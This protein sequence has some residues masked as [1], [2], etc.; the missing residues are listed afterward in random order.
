MRKILVPLAIT[1]IAV[2]TGCQEEIVNEV[3]PEIKLKTTSVS[4]PDTG[5]EGVIVFK[6]NN[7]SADGKLV[8]TSADEWISGLQ[9]A[10]DTTVVFT[11]AAND[12][13]EP[14]NGKVTLTY[15]WGT[16]MSITSEVPVTLLAAAEEPEPEVDY[17]YEFEMP[18]L[19]GNFYTDMGN[20]GEYNYYTWLMDVPFDENGNP[21]AGGT[22]YLLDIFAAET[23]SDMNN[24]LPPAGTYVLG[25][26]MGTADMTFGYDYSIVEAYDENMTATMRRHFDGG[27]VEISYEGS[28]IVIDA[29]LADEAEETHHVTYKGQPNFTPDDGGGEDPDNPSDDYMLKEDLDIN[30]TWAS[31]EYGYDDGYVMQVSMQFTD[32]EVIGTSATPP[33]NLLIVDTYMPPKYDG[34]LAT[35]Y[36]D[37]NESFDEYSVATG[38]DYEGYFQEGTYVWCYDE[39]GNEIAL[40]LVSGGTMEISGDMGWYTVECDFTTTG[41]VSVTCYYEGPLSLEGLPGDG[42]SST[43]T[44]DYT[45]DLTGCE[46]SAEYYGDYFSS[47]GGDWWIDISGGSDTPD[48]LQ[49]ELATQGLDFNAGIISG[50]YAP[51]PDINYVM[52]MEYMTG[53][54]DGSYMYGTGYYSEEGDYA[55]AVSGDL[56]VTNHGDG[57]YTFKFAF[58]D[59]NG[60]IWDGEWTGEMMHYDASGYYG[61][62][63]RSQYVLKRETMT[64]KRASAESHI[65]KVNGSGKVSKVLSMDKNA[66]AKRF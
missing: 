38:Q 13:Q 30:A 32:M 27:T 62:P 6:I 47:G 35:G 39:E 48:G 61:A 24:P 40:G 1:A 26:P 43:L 4:I 56:N 65:L 7:P 49:I 60:N 52:P 14:K 46:G 41:G 8:P 59:G 44:G 63:R 45:L 28:D 10:S 66:S 36:F 50:T 64:P 5:G 23:P 53:I 34:S 31:A 37:V 19:I 21:Q 18:Y 29:V 12:T 17:D 54:M 16:D 25:E 55:V 33:G 11:A 42:S 51:S 20:N 15:S 3:P 57:T 9:T 22:Y 2:I 58:D